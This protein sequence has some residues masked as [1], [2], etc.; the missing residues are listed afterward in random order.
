MDARFRLGT[1]QLILFGEA[2]EINGGGSPK[3]TRD[4]KNAD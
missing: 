4:I 3:S 2:E 1:T